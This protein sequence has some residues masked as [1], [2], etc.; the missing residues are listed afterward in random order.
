MR[1]G[2]SHDRK[3]FSLWRRGWDEDAVTDLR[4][5][6][7]IAFHGVCDSLIAVAGACL[8]VPL[9]ITV[10]LKFIGTLTFACISKDLNASTRL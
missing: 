6:I 2:E 10:T 1:D 3:D 8:L 7:E 4:V 5:E 9:R